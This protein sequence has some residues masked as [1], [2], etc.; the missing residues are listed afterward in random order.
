MGTDQDALM[1]RAIAWFGGTLVVRQAP[2]Y[3]IRIS[4]GS[5]RH[6]SY[7]IYAGFFA[8]EAEPRVE[9][10]SQGITCA[11]ALPLLAT[12]QVSRNMIGTYEKEL[13]SE[14]GPIDYR[15]S[16][17]RAIDLAKRHQ[18]P[19]AMIALAALN[20]A[21]DAMSQPRLDLR[22]IMGVSL[23]AELNRFRYLAQ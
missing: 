2:H 12:A 8:G 3:Q 5:N 22:V 10:L 19:V 23:A 21:G 11:R 4:G 17:Q 14:F 18:L 20:E 7:V 1:Q 9:T 13:R 16:Q 6:P 15:A